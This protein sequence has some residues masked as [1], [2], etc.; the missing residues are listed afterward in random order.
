M[1]HEQDIPEN[2]VELSNVRGKTT[3]IRSRSTNPMKILTPRRGG[4]SAWI[5]TSNFGG[6]LV[7]GD[8]IHLKIRAHESTT[9]FLTTQASTK[10]YRSQTQLP[11]RQSLETWVG[12]GARFVL[13]PDPITCFAESIYEQAQRFDLESGAELAF[14][15]W[16][17]SGRSAR[18]ECWAFSRY[19]SR[20]E[21][22]LDGKCI[23]ADALVLDPADGPL[24]CNARMGSYKCAGTIVMVGGQFEGQFKELR[25][26]TEELAGRSDL[27]AAAS[28]IPAGV[29]L[30]IAGDST[31]RVSLFIRER[32]SFITE[33]L[34]EDPWE[35]KW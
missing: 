20:N 26:V 5:Y 8:E 12:R 1:P 22:Y 11:C 6:G 19:Q 35:R 32:L 7:A 16:F 18:G 30:R 31:Q 24:D 2:Y 14:V 3:V 15:D 34:Q 33:W 13:V 28:P 4:E 21:V 25:A 17:T 23:L 29:L 27:T 9:T 10:V